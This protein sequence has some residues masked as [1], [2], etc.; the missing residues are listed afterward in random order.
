MADEQ[1]ITGPIGAQIFSDGRHTV[2]R[3]RDTDL[4]KI[5]YTDIRLDRG[6]SH[7]F[8]TQSRLNQTS[9]LFDLDYHITHRGGAWVVQTSKGVYPFQDGMHLLRG[10]GQDHEFITYEADPG[11]VGHWPGEGGDPP[12]GR[13][14]AASREKRQ[15]AYAA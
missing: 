13:T 15:E 1:S 11:G 2:V 7:S 5:A 14:L 8:I 4:V 6:G 10:V 3:F 12:P 9:R